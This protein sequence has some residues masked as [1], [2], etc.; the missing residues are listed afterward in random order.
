MVSRRM[1]EMKIPIPPIVT[2]ARESPCA[3]LYGI[4]TTFS[5]S[6]GGS[7]PKFK[8]AAWEYAQKLKMKHNFISASHWDA[9]A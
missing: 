1:D 4:L 8:S 5:L 3:I 9:Y 6:S 2:M 7:W